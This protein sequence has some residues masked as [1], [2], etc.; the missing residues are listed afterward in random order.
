MA[1]AFLA[2]F[3]EGAETILFLH[4]AAGVAGGWS[5]GMLAGAVG[6]LSFLAV[7][8][9]AIDRLALALPLRPVFA[10]TSAFLFVMALR[11]VAGAVQE[12]QEQQLLPFDAV[13]VPEWLARIGV[14]T[15]VESLAAQ[16]LVL[17][18]AIAG[19][20]ALRVQAPARTPQG[21]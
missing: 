4:V 18:V 19:L 8:F 16:A 9:V 15:T 21:A 7:I 6:A 14:G 10:V 12:V 1:L 17:A 2:V 3:R 20:I 13:A 11:F 5:T